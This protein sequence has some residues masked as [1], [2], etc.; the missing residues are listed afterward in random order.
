[1]IK[2]IILFSLVIS[3]ILTSCSSNDDAASTETQL[4][5]KENLSKTEFPVC[6]TLE[7]TLNTS[8]TSKGNAVFKN[9]NSWITGQTIRIRFVGGSV[10]LQN[11]IKEYASE[12]TSAANLNFVYVG[13]NDES[14][15]AIFFETGSNYTF[16][17]SINF[18]QLS[19]PN[20]T[21]EIIRGITLHEFGHLLGL[22][23]ENQSPAANIQ[24]NKPVVYDYYQRV[25]GWSKEQVDSQIFNALPTSYYNTYTPYDSSSVMT[26]SF[27][28]SFTTNGFSIPFISSLSITD[29][30]FIA[31]A[32]PFPVKSKLYAGDRITANNRLTSPNGNYTLYIRSGKL[33]LYSNVEF[34]DHGHISPN[35]KFS[36]ATSSNIYLE[37]REN[38][39]LLFKG[40]VS[41]TVGPNIPVGNIQ[42]INLNDSGNIEAIINGVVVF[43]INM[44]TDL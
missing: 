4:I 20:A 5:N 6:T 40:N 8:T 7:K 16:G 15:A 23:H 29:R 19:N 1:M 26:Y 21:D 39:L 41:K 17:R 25:I 27:P 32:F 14:D 12:W 33:V 30:M 11:K 28:A 43:T 9:N 2:K 38:V 18:G 22:H 35:I 24:W 13:T 44:K 37:I 3:Q 10:E 42:Y 36:N 31:K 34:R